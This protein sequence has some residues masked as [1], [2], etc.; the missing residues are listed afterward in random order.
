MFDDDDND[1]D[2]DEWRVVTV[3]LHKLTNIVT[4]LLTYLLTLR[5]S[6]MPIL[7]TSANFFL[8][9]DHITTVK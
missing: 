6:R 2:D 1:D 4:Y 3:F 8:A 7:T 9:S 5:S